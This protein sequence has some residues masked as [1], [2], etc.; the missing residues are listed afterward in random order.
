M[1][2]TDASMRKLLVGGVLAVVLGAA[3]SVNDATSNVGNIDASARQ[4]CTDLRAVVQA[5]ASGSL[6]PA[7][8][9]QRIGKVYS[10]AS[11]SANPILKAKAVAVFTDATQLVASGE[12]G[13]L[14]ADL[15]SMSQ[16]CSSVNG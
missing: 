14:D 8:L 6:S 9:Q 13:S 1:K 5:R 11:S 12:S 3:C 4:A 2:P 7:D 15:S 10:E 16:T